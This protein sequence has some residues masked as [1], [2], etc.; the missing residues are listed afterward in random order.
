MWGR[1]HIDD[2]GF[3]YSQS[4]GWE[5]AQDPG[6]DVPRN[7]TAPNTTPATNAQG[8]VEPDREDRIP[9]YYLQMHLPGEDDDGFISMRPFVNASRQDEQKVLTSFM[10]AKSDRGDFGR[11]VVYDVDQSVEGPSLVA[12]NINSTP[13]IAQQITQLNQ[14]GSEAVFGNLL[15]VPIE[16]TLLYVRP[17][18]VK[19]AG[20]TQVPRLRSVILAV[21]DTIV[22]DDTLRGAMLKLFGP[23][24]P[25]R[26]G[27]AEDILATLD[28]ILPDTGD[29]DVDPAGEE[30]DPSDE[31]ATIEELLTEADDLFDQA[32]QALADGDLGTYQELVEEAG[33]NVAEALELAEEADAE[34]SGGTDAPGAGDGAESGT[35][36]EPG[37]DAG[38]G[39]DQAEADEEAPAPDGDSGPSPPEGGAQ[40]PTTV[41]VSVAS[42]P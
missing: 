6:T 30:V 12:S 18:Y 10:V 23:G 24:S 19:A 8:E 26:E 4:D 42:P 3:F 34:A 36:A 11:L 2:P 5:V 33:A 39:D 1:Y 37:T 14:Q 29:D 9:P 27:N 7:T 25:V 41:T 35:D 21:G 38:G 28:Q 31:V 13:E 40:P 22:I 17:L 15:L 20:D 32:D 16:D